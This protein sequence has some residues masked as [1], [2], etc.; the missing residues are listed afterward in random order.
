M[1]YGGLRESEGVGATAACVSVSVRDFAAPP[2]VC[3]VGPVC[4]TLVGVVRRIAWVG[5]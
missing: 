4:G 3:L 2:G 5:E 1:V